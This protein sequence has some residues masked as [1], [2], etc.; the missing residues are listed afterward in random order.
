MV[1]TKENPVETKGDPAVFAVQTWVNLKYGKV[2][3]F[4]PAPLNG[5][6]GWS[7]VYA[8]TRALQIELGITSLADAFGPTTASKYKQ[9]GEM[10][11]GKV[12]TDEKGKAIVTI[13]K[14]A[15]YCK[16][17]N[18][19][20]FDDVFDEKTKNAVV[21]L[22][23]DAGLPVTDGTVYDYIFKA[24][25]TMDAYRLT[26]GGDAKVRQIQQD[27]NNKY[28]KTSEVQPTDGH[29]QRGTN[30][31][32][33]YG[34]QTEMG[35]A[36][37]SQTG[38]I[39]PATKNG[40]P[41]LKVGSSGRFVTLFQYA[42]YFNGH[43]SGSFSTTYNA[44]VESAVKKFQEFTLLPQ[45]GVANKSTWL[46]ALVSTG[47]P[48]RKGQACDCITEVTLE[49]GKAL[50]AAGYETVGRYLVNVAGGINKKIQ[51]GEL[52]N[53]FDAGLSVFPIYQANGREAS[54]FSA[55]KGRADAVAAY[56]AAKEYG[57]KDDTTIYFAVDFD[58]YGTDITDNILPH[59]KALNE[60]MAQL[61]GSY[62]IG[63]YGARN[64]C[65]QVSE[66]G[67]AKTSFVSGMST[68]FSGNL[69]YPLPKNWAF[70]QISTI[71]VGSGSGLIE[72]DNN[73]KSKRD[74][75]VKEIE[76]EKLSFTLQL[77][78]MAN[79]T[80][81]ETLKSEEED[82][83]NAFK[84]PGGWVLYKKHAKPSITSFDV[85]VYRKEISKEKY[86]YTVAFRGS[87]QWQDW[88]IQDLLQVALN[89][90]GLQISEAT[91]FVKELIETD[92][93]KMSHLYITGHS[94][95]GYLAQ[96]VQSEMI[97]ENI[98]WVESNA[99]TFNAPGLS[100]NI[101]FLDLTHQA[102][103]IKKLASN[104]LKK[105]D[106]FIINHRIEQDKISKF[107]FDLGILYAYDRY[108]KTIEDTEGQ[109]EIIG[110]YHSCSRFKEVNLK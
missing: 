33:V 74:N 56:N 79:N 60:K 98:P 12:P 24:F 32:L 78:E 77:A 44:N 72:I 53:I 58:A 96:W 36:A 6:T 3:G 83:A 27:L 35:I 59:F 92:G 4:Q 99:V 23:K 69:G 42:L 76:K 63:V 21:S 7:T 86:A 101:N 8:L 46:S 91:N 106:D 37:G 20:K 45:D 87:Q 64:V 11:L 85:Y 94:L 66:K 50:K 40:L 93:K 26:P 47:D 17:Y 48:D 25:L 61:G 34:L 1:E 54:S 104:Q 49:R 90:G 15:M 75:G 13:L 52:K 67:Y 19:G 39:G 5:K 105:Y 108:N 38:S 65:I 22:Q 103:V 95:G 10:T 62:K 43:D 107:G 110:Y 14:G 100:P 81:K 29:Y 68:G 55:D 51:P 71:K 102:K 70:D 73:I 97:D 31:A 88:V 80:Y 82:P 18:P 2:A 109:K 89:V 57:F 30:K 9:W 28:Y 41:I 84:S 16:G